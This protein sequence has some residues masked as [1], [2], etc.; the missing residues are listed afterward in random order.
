M[1][2][3]LRIGTRNLVCWYVGVINT[4]Q[5]YIWP[6]QD[7]QNVSGWFHTSI[8]HSTLIPPVYKLVKFLV[9]IFSSVT[10]NKNT[11]KDLFYFLS[12]M[13]EQNLSLFMGSLDIDLSFG[14][15]P[16]EETISICVNSLCQ[17]T[18]SCECVNKN[19]FSSY[20]TWR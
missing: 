15:I 2:I 9:W 5:N 13:F 14:I 1:V 6:K 16:F 7:P 4:T 20:Y 17:N 8:T 12:E 3:G 18:K 10:I 11:D 19:E